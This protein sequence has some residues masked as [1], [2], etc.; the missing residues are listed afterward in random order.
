[1]KKACS[2]D[3]SAASGWSM[4]LTLSSLRAS[5]RTL[6]RSRRD[7]ACN[8]CGSNDMPGSLPSLAA[9]PAGADAAA[10]GGRGALPEGI[11]LAT[12]RSST[13]RLSS[14]SLIRH[15]GQGGRADAV[16]VLRNRALQ[17]VQPRLRRTAQPLVGRLQGRNQGLGAAGELRLLLRQSQGRFD[18]DDEV[19]IAR[20]RQAL[21]QFF[22]L[23]ALQTDFAY[24][25][26]LDGEPGRHLAHAVLRRFCE[27]AGFCQSSPLATSPAAASAAT[28]HAQRAGNWTMP[29]GS[30]C[31]GV[32]GTSSAGVGGG[33]EELSLM[34]FRFYRAQCGHDV[35]ESGT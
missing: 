3:S 4:R 8:S 17:G 22:E 27:G 20:T 11:A 26:F 32:S 23:R 6:S 18:I 29:A 5:S 33:A 31:C 19:F 34:G 9:T 15:V 13:R 24:P 30:G 10:T 12:G 25:G 35:N 21:H 16:G 1:M 28:P 7:H 14:S 2:G